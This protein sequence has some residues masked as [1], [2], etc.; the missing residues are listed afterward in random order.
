MKYIVY[1]FRLP[2]IRII[3]GGKDSLTGDTIRFVNK[4]RFLNH[5]T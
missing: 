3:C 2:P 1:K 4:M 5:D